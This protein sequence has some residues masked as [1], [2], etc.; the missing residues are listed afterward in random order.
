MLGNP[1][2]QLKGK[3]TIECLIHK[4]VL[5]Y[6]HVVICLEIL[7][8]FLKLNSSLCKLLLVE[9]G[10]QFVVEQIAYAFQRYLWSLYL[11]VFHL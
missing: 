9:V 5:Q 3:L 7:G 8:V 6:F 2:P 4:R 11:G 10:A 1:D